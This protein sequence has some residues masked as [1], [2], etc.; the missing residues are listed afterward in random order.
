MIHPLLLILYLYLCLF[1]GNAGDHEA[2]VLA[3][4]TRSPVSQA[5]DVFRA[6]L[7]VEQLKGKG[8]LWRENRSQEW[9]R[10]LSS[11][12][13][14]P[15][16]DKR[17]REHFRVSKQTFRYLC[18]ELGPTIRRKDTRFRRAISV[19]VR[20]AVTL[21]FLARGGYYHQVAEQFGIGKSTVCDILDDTCDAIWSVLGDRYVR[22]PASYDECKRAARDWQMLHGLRMPN[23]VG[24]IDGTHIGIRKPAFSG[25]AYWNRKRFYSFNCQAVCDARGRFIDWES[26]APGSY[27]DGRVFRQSTLG[28]MLARN[29]L[30]NHARR[31]R[32]PG[33]LGTKDIPFFLIGDPGYPLFS[34]LMKRRLLRRFVGRFPGRLAGRP[35]GVWGAGLPQAP[36]GLCRALTGVAGGVVH[37][38][39]DFPN[40]RPKLR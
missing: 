25:T 8:R 36:Q 7:A 11:N 28:R 12:R 32:L 2:L 26:G 30:L 18:D 14:G 35:L 39:G 38:S 40:F 5:T 13:E 9:S 31:F 16:E 29:A 24:A 4:G 21:W 33:G 3:F 1:G 19:E 6:W 15:R 20:V 27:H 17:W 22:F 37:G 23:I 34:Y 10:F